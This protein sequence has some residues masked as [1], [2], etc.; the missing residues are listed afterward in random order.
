MTAHATSTNTALEAAP[1]TTKWQQNDLGKWSLFSLVDYVNEL[2]V[3]WLLSNL[4]SFC[5]GIWLQHHQASRFWD[6]S[7]PWHCR[8]WRLSS[9][10][11]IHPLSR[12]LL[13]WCQVSRETLL[14]NWKFFYKCFLVKLF[15]L[16]RRNWSS[17]PGPR[18]G[19]GSR[20][21]SG[22][23]LRF[24]FGPGVRNLWKTGSGVT[25]PFRQ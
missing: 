14:N 23:I 2:N 17:Q 16:I 7:H 11:I 24:S 20:V 25:F 21:D 9:G 4:R 13:S 18:G 1:A 8:G 3:C 19:T 6:H 12:W 22:R 15:A 10:P 5:D